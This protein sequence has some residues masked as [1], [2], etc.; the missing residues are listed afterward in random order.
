MSTSVLITKSHF[1]SNKNVDLALVGQGV[2]YVL[3]KL[4]R[5]EQWTWMYMVVPRKGV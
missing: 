4:A 5:T 3:D 2:F 1:H